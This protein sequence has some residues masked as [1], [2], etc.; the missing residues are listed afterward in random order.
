VLRFL[1]SVKMREFV[2]IADQVVGFRPHDRP[3]FH[4]GLLVCHPARPCSLGVVTVR[5][6]GNFFQQ[7]PAVTWDFLFRTNS[8]AW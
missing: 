2:M 5:C 6:R 7:L 1:L 3:P 8:R 4:C